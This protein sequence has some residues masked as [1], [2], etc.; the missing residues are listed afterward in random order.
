MNDPLLITP[1]RMSEMGIPSQYWEIKNVTLNG[2]EQSVLMLTHREYCKSF[3]ANFWYRIMSK[4]MK[5]KKIV[6]RDFDLE[7][8]VI[9]N[10][11]NFMIINPDLSIDFY[12]T[13]TFRGLVVIPLNP[14]LIVLLFIIFTISWLFMFKSSKIIC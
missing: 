9:V 6:Y 3:W 13:D 10:A 4:R 8:P 7:Q 14:L 11:D 5:N 12:Q 1:T 2:K